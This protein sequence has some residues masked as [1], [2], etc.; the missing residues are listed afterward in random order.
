LSNTRSLGFTILSFYQCFV[1]RDSCLA[2]K[3]SNQ[4]KPALRPLDS[5]VQ[6]S[7]FINVLLPV[8]PRRHEF[9]SSYARRYRRR[10]PENLQGGPGFK[11]SLYDGSRIV[12]DS[13]QGWKTSQPLPSQILARP[14]PRSVLSNRPPERRPIAVESDSDV[15]IRGSS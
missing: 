4:S 3:A 12:G 1:R 14:R 6:F 8:T 13:R 5:L 7:A 2:R 11:Q 10:Y 15:H 9:P